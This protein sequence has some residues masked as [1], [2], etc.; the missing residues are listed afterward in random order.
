MDYLAHH[1]ILGMKWGIRRYQN[2]DGSLTPAGQKRYNKL[3]SELDRLD[4]AGQKSRRKKKVSEMTD[5][6]L[7]DSI[8][9][10]RAEKEY[11]DL[12]SALYPARP[13][14]MSKLKEK[15]LYD[16]L[17]N[18]ASE[19]VKKLSGEIMSKALEEYKEKNKTDAQ[20]EADKKKKQLED[21]KWQNEYYNNLNQAKNNKNS[22]FG[23]KS[24]K[25]IALENAKYDKEYYQNKSLAEKFKKDYE[26]FINSNRVD[27]EN[28][29]IFDGDGP[30]ASR[31]DDFFKDF[32]TTSYSSA[33]S[34]DS[35]KSGE[36]WVSYFVPNMNFM[37]GRYMLEDYKK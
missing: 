26:A 25:D 5:D 10:L 17:P 12:N 24:L 30:S 36:D 37:L 18:V 3:K 1:G 6:E 2:K 23:E 33:S 31:V 22:Y 9:R 4:G 14:V 8:L 32:G 11:K 16:T 21:A 19:S 15:M 20:R 7:K 27:A 34:S 28:V 29:G 35:A 13:T